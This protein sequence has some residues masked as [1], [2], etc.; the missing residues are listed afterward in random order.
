M[1]AKREGREGNVEWY[2][3]DGDHDGRRQ[4]SEVKRERGR[5]KGGEL[6]MGRWTIEE[7]HRWFG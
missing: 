4:V 1:N 3:G 7:L 6:N 5:E 2:F